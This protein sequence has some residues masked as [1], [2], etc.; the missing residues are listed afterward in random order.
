MVVAARPPIEI[1]IV[2]DIVCPWCYIGKK[3]LERALAERP[4]LP[5]DVTWLPFQLSPDMPR[6]G[7]DRR[8]HY[9]SI[10]GA[11]RAQQIIDG[12]ANRGRDDGIAFAWQPGARSPNTLSAHVLLYWAAAMPGVDQNA[13]AEKLFHAHHVACENLSDPAVLARIAGDVGMDPGAVH[14]KLA[15]GLDED[16]VQSMIAQA[17]KAGVSGVPF[18]IFSGKYAL[19]GAQPPEAILEVLDQ[20]ANEPPDVAAAH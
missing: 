6:E 13:L 1:Q 14:E 4:D 11:D 12:M 16:A 20:L 3:R 19:S 8:E 7:R 18:F 15:A 10:F 2:S 9:A 17:Q 5:V